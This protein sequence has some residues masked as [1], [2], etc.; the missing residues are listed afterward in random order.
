MSKKLSQILKNVDGIEGRNCKDYLVTGI[1]YDS[2][3]IKEGYIFAAIRGKKFN[4][5][6]FI[7]EAIKNGAVA[8]LGGEEINDENICFLKCEDVRGAIGEIANFIFNNPSRRLYTIGV[9]GTNGKTTIVYL[10]DHIFNTVGIKHGIVSTVENKTPQKIY[11]S[12]L[13]TPEAPE[14][15]NLMYKT[16]KEDGDSFILEVSSHS[17]DYKRIYGTSFNIAI[18]TN[19]TQDHLDFYGDMEKYFNSKLKLFTEYRPII[20]IINT[21]DEYGKRIYELCNGGKFSYGFNEGSDFRILDFKNVENGISFTIS[22]HKGKEYNVK[23]NLIGDFN[24]Y[25]ITASFIASILR[26][27]KYGDV[28]KGI[29]SF[30]GVRGRMEFVA[31]YNGAKIY[32]DFA[33]TP[34][35][36]YETLKSVKEIV[37]DGRVIVLFGA[38]GERDSGKRPLMG[39]AVSKFSNYAIITSDNPRSEDPMKIIEDIKKGFKNENYDI[40][41]DRKEAIK[42]AINL[43]KKGDVLILAGKGHED[44]QVIGDKMIP[45]DEREIVLQLI[46]EK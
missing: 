3:R 12:K 11:K 13:T 46:G 22:D 44:Y 39:E 28:L 10:L 16:V 6:E 8:V 14:V 38:G 21:D 5:Y 9:T 34:S 18:F 20:S 7:E 15:V 40:E 19:L 36:L 4:G 24:A 37:K 26:G 27:I 33:H 41:V 42:K 2:R 25:N 30:K 32:I 29:S 35:A 45:F 23:S 1:S 31:E 17:I 43:L